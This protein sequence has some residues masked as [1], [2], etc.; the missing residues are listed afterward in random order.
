MKEN[1]ITQ[2]TDIE[3]ALLRPGQYIGSIS[4]TKCETFILN[5]ESE[6]F[7]YKEFEY[8]PGLLKIIYEIL[9]NSVDESI[10]TGFKFGTNIS[11]EIKNNRI[12]ISDNGR[13]IPL[14]LAE[15]SKK[16]QLELALTELRA[17]SNFNDEEGRN[18]LGMNGVGSSLTNIFSLLFKAT[19][20]DGKRKGILTC[21]NN[22]STKKCVI[23]DYVSDITGTIIEF[24]PD[25]A[26]FGLTEIDEIHKNLLYQRLMF[27]S[28]MYSEITF[29][30]NGK[31]VR[32]KNSKN[33]MSVFADKF[34]AITDDNKPSKYTIGIIPNHNDDFTHKSYI[35]GADCINGGN[36]IDYIHSE[37]IS[38]IKEKLNKKYSSIKPGDIKNK[39]TYIVIFRE[40]INPMFNSQTKENF[41]SD[42]NQIKQFLKDVDW[43]AFAQ[44]IV[45][46][47][48]IMD[49]ILETFK[50]KEELKN[51]QA[52]NSLNKSSK[53]F[54][55]DKFLPATKENKYYLICEGASASGGLSA[56]LGRSE[57][58]YYATRGVPLNAYEAS[59]ARLSDNVE[60]SEMI[61]I[62][63]LSFKDTIQSLTYENIIIA[64]DA[65]C[66]EEHTKIYTMR[67]LV[68]LN[69]IKYGDKVLTHLNRCK[70]VTNIIESYKTECVKITI[71][72]KEIM[73]SP[74]H[75]LIVVQ[76]NNIKYISA[77]N[78]KTTDQLLKY[79][80]NHNSLD[81]KY[82]LITPSKV[83]I[84]SIPK[85][86]FIDITVDEDNT[87]FFENNDRELIL[88]HNC[89]GSHIV[90]L[91]L[92]FFSKYYPDIILQ[93]RLK[94]LRTP[95][96]VFKDKKTDK[97]K[98]FFF[99]LDEYNKFIKEHDTSNLK[100]HY[101]KG[102]GSWEPDDLKPLIE[103]YG[104][105]Y[106]LE[107]FI[108]D[109]KYK[110]TIDNWLN[111]KSSDKRKEYLNNNEFS[112]FKI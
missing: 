48:E 42:V 77:K 53:R 101:Y 32:F 21:K 95:I 31:I 4:K 81:I 106:F 35:N 27:L 7:E 74:N 10:R 52:L 20:Y 38:R 3:H 50:I 8:V 68:P 13:G 63:N 16:S 91:Y 96:I 61:K 19:V 33:I 55:S 83:E 30:F 36:H 102:L 9:D 15:G 103:K 94:H 85:T 66:L 80:D 40:F 54:K 58:G 76:N 78:L 41:S 26:R 22:L 45:K 37:L 72:G 64:T 14:D 28:Y 112:I 57:Y 67:G 29:K 39:L 62:L 111:S 24:E 65:D 18:L 107:T 87:F 51:R 104:I 89:D 59:V 98:Y 12:K 99:T 43:D 71:N 110:D 105:E 23:N 108:D 88:T 56:C 79:K 6:K 93:G 34:V 49:P 100:I 11:V 75:K 82:D 5:K 86:K 17:G 25:F 70:S 44:K 84:C 69:E 1:K 47:N 60:L 46:C 92:G 90:G 109:E 2:L 97:I 73:V